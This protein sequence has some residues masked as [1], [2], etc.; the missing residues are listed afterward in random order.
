MSAASSETIINV[1][2]VRNYLG[3]RWVHSDVSFS[4]KRGEIV[5]IIGGSGCGKT[6]LI[7]SLLRL[8]TPTGGNISVF[9]TDI[10]NASEQE[11]LSVQKRWGVMFQGSA[12][13]SSL[14]VLE[15]VLY[16]LHEYAHLSRHSQ[17]VLAK[18]KIA[19]SG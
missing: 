8:N 19:L 4:V 1:A 12:L 17:V 13:F 3:G 10:L 2:H 16:V 18:I 6:T 14:T 5:A 7:R 9:G 15:N 11:L